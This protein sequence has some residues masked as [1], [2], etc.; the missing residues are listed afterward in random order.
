MSA[1][2]PI[3]TDIV[4]QVTGGG[5]DLVKGAKRAVGMKDGAGLFDSLDN[6][7]NQTLGKDSGLGKVGDQLS[8]EAAR[9]TAEKAEKAA[10]ENEAKQ[11]ARMEEESA[12]AK[13]RK[14]FAAIRNRQRSLSSAGSGRAGTILTTPLGSTGTAGTTGKT[15]LGS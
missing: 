7:Y 14:E 13:Q 11:N 4:K 1:A 8:G 6:F 9:K 5:V 10:L 3:I 15:L 2:P 12:N